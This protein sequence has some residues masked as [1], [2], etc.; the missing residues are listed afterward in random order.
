MEKE[1]IIIKMEKLNI[2]EIILKA[3]EKEMDDIIRKMENIIQVNS[4]MI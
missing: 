2:K 3:K 4:K 1:Q